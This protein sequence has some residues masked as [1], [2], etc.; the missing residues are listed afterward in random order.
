MK[1]RTSSSDRSQGASL[2]EL[3]VVVVIVLLISAIAMRTIAP[4]FADRQIRE[5][6]RAV[7]VFLNSARNRA[8]QTGRPAGVWLDRMQG[9]PEACASLSYA[10]VPEPYSGD[11]AD[12]GLV[13]YIYPNIPNQKEYINIVTPANSLGL[14]LDTWYTPDPAVQNLVRPGDILRIGNK[15]LKYYLDTNERLNTIYSTLPPPPVWI[16]AIGRNNGSLTAPGYD[17][18][19]VSDSSGNKTWRINWWAFGAENLTNMS[20]TIY[21]VISAGA[22]DGSG[23]NVTPAMGRTL[24][25]QILRRPVK[26]ASGS[27]QLPEGAVIDL[28]FSGDQF[29][30]Y[31]PRVQPGLAGNPSNPYIGY[32]VDVRGN[33]IAP[34][35]TS[36]VE[37]DLPVIIMFDPNG[38]VEQVYSRVWNFQSHIW[39]WKG[40][41]PFVPIFLLVGKRE[42]VPVNG[43]RAFT[44]QSEMGDQTTIGTNWMDPKCLWV[45]VT[46][47]TGLVTCSEMSVIGTQYVSVSTNPLSPFTMYGPTGSW[48]LNRARVLAMQFQGMGGK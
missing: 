20:G 36:Y 38:S 32:P 28:N 40:D 12:S 26:M 21:P 35:N 13:A 31:H 45:A 46:P 47:A 34:T 48:E 11:Y 39:E 1:H 16:I 43:Q 10:Q 18:V 9:L 33:P 25:F 8:I 44:V 14:G 7:N 2:L 5:A 3:M 42:K 22:P 19:Q 23:K 15:G 6:A 4:M 17:N 29:K 37:D 27:I 41:R 30:P 24:P